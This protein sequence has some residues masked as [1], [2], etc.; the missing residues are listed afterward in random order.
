M[1]AGVAGVLVGGTAL[2]APYVID[3][4]GAPNTLSEA[5]VFPGGF[6]DEIADL[7]GQTAV[8]EADIVRVD[9]L[10]KIAQPEYSQPTDR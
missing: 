7:G 6:S 2:R 9:S 1:L 3:A 4:I 10:H 8:E 5:M